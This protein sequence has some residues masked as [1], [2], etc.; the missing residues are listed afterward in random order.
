M[1]QAH[2]AL[3]GVLFF[4]LSL[5]FAV[6]CFM[7][8]W[9]DNSLDASTCLGIVATV[10]GAGFAWFVMRYADGRWAAAPN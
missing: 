6:S 1:P 7:V 9:L 8:R 4:S 3:G 2:R 10:A 5:L